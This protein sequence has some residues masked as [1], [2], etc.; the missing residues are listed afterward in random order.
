MRGIVCRFLQQIEIKNIA[1]AGDGGAALGKLRDETFDL[2]I[3]DLN[4]EPM[5]GL[6]VLKEVSADKKLG[7]LPFIMVTAETKTENITAAEVAGVRLHRGSLPP[8]RW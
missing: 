3:S 4:M 8:I 2:V 7:K 5:S 1:E 6:Q